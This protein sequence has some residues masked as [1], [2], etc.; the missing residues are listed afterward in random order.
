MT[1]QGE[2]GGG[3]WVRGRGGARD[4]KMKEMKTNNPTTS[5]LC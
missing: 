4:G 3:G 1:G 2:G 5:H